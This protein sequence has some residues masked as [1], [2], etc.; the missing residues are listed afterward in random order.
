M[1]ETHYNQSI[2]H[3]SSPVRRSH[4]SHPVL[5]SLLVASILP[6]AADVRLPNIFTDNMLLQRDMPVRVWGWADA[7]ESVSVALMGTTV[8]TKADDK[9]QWSL[10]L[11]AIKSGENLELTVH[12]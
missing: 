10:E 1:N 12:M 2:M 5:L 11:P 9:G 4:K 6:A 7:G 8:A 3:I